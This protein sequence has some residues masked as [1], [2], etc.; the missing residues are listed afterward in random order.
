[1]SAGAPRP[2]LSIIIPAYNEARRLPESIARLQG[3]LQK[4]P[5]LSEVLVVDD[6]SADS[7]SAVVRSW[8]GRW[9]ALRL[10]QTPHQGKGAAVRAGALAAQGAWIYLA[11]ADFSVPIEE[12]SRFLAEPPARE[13][14]RIGSREA[15]GAHRYG[16]PYFRHVMGRVFNLVVRALVVPGISDT[17]CGFKLLR[18]EAALDLFLHQTVP[19]WTFDVELLYIARMRGYS[20]REIPVP[21]YYRTGSK[22]HPA[23]DTFGMLGDLF[24]IRRNALRGRYQRRVVPHPSFA[25]ESEVIASFEIEAHN[26]AA[27]L[28]D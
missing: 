21:W 15:P 16:E 27:S 8:M 26:S 17:Q 12:M 24:A 10:I 19:G 6:G 1:M 25:P 9:H 4:Q 11:D 22:V 28:P 20:V 14:L 5:F 18:R 23:R 2:E 13:D 7:T 3:Y